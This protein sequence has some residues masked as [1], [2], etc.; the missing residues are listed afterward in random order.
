MDTRPEKPD[1]QL[2]IEIEAPGGADGFHDADGRGQRIEAETEEGVVNSAAEGL[3]VGEA[4][5]DAAAFHPLG[6]GV[7]S[8]DRFA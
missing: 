6:R 2:G 7:G 4:V 8:E 3:E 1:G 5:A